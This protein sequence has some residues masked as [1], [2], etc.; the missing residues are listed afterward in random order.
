MNLP[1]IAFT[2]STAALTCVALSMLTFLPLGLLPY[3]AG[4]F[5]LSFFVAF[6]SVNR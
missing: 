3:S 2:V 4:A 6:V 1:A 5:S